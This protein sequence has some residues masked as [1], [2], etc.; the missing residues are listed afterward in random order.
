MKSLLVKLIGFPATLIHGDTLVLDRWIWLKERLPKTNNSE[1]FLDIGCGTG[2]FTTYASLRGYNAL[3]LSWDE[4]NQNVAKERASLCKANSATFEVQ[5][6]RKL[7][8]RQDLI[9]QFDVAICFENI[10][11]IIDDQ[12]LMCDIAKCLKR[13]GKLLLTTPNWDYKPISEGDS[14]PFLLIENGGHV[15]KG[16]TKEKL[17][18]LCY[19]AGLV[20]DSFS[21]CSGLV[22][23]KTT[24]MLRLLS[25]VNHIF[26]WGITLPL[27]IIP[28]ILDPVLSKIVDYPSY[29]ICLEAH[30]K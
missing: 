16:Y 8:E 2:A 23:Q 28:P 6:V 3:G 22:S 9:N 10:E 17:S 19:I 18:E 21:F 1:K 7:D 24:F 15:R 5:D 14:G 13:G 30:K 12:K 25:K 20:P 11:H 26:A 4:R 29:S 27:R